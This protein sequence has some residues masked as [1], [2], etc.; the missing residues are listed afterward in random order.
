MEN[1]SLDD[2]L[3]AAQASA[4]ARF[5]GTHL[6]P[7][8]LDL[9]F[10]VLE[11]H[12]RGPRPELKPARVRSLYADQR[13]N[14]RALMAT[15]TGHGRALNRYRMP[16]Q[17]RFEL[18]EIGLAA[19]A[20][21]TRDLVSELLD[22]PGGVPEEPGRRELLDTTEGVLQALLT[23]YQLVFRFDYDKGRFWY[24]RARPRVHRCA[25]RILDL[26]CMIQQVRTLRYR[27]LDGVTW[28]IAHTVF[29]VMLDYEQVE[30]PLDTVGPLL[31]SRR[32]D[33]RCLNDL[34]AT[35]Q[36]PWILD[37]M[38]WPERLLPFVLDYCR[39]LRDG[40]RFLPTDGATCGEYQALTGSYRDQEPNREAVREGEGPVLL[41]DYSILA[42]QARADFE[43]LRKSRATRNRFLLPRRFARL[44]RSQQLTAGHLMTRIGDRH[45][46]R[47]TDPG[48]R[49]GHHDLRIHAGF[50][51]VFEH[52][53]AIFDPS[54]AIADQRGLSDLFAQR[55]AFIGED[56]TATESSL[57]HV[58]Q[59]APGQLRLQTQETRFSYRLAIGSFLAYG[60][61]ETGIRQPRLGKVA[62]IHRPGTGF[63]QIDLA[64]LAD[65]ARPAVV[66]PRTAAMPQDSADQPATAVRALLAY[67]EDTGW[68]LVLPDSEPFWEQAKVSL[69]GRDKETELELGALRDLGEGY[70]L[71][72]L[73]SRPGPDQAPD[74]GQGQRP[75][76]PPPRGTSSGGARDVAALAPAPALMSEPE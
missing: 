37:C 28:R 16:P 11:P 71:F 46:P 6:P 38:A 76:Y 2:A 43:E 39:S 72:Q 64:A 13:E 50:Q 65:Y 41:I 67:S 12:R 42:E 55:S 8:T 22:G 18:A 7:R 69:L 26:I 59:E 40:V 30:I 68:G 61:G 23:A 63:V 10:A 49:P 19:V 75:H 34:Y 60:I 62:R 44:D 31:G 45:Q 14:H 74:Q 33:Q 52:L 66:R 25:H 73:R 9:R 47:W 20:A 29:R 53:V 15:V 32:G 27:R 3:L 57:W 35:L 1:R 58:L 21:A 54:G 24:V 36:V 70:C 56:H 4:W 51:D 17:E 5:L 48:H